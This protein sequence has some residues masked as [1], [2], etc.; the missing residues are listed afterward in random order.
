M[1]YRI[2]PHSTINQ[3]AESELREPP[4]QLRSLEQLKERYIQRKKRGVVKR[5][6][7]LSQPQPITSLREVNKKSLFRGCESQYI[8]RTSTH[9]APTFIP[10]KVSV[11]TSLLELITFFHAPLQNS[12]YNVFPLPIQSQFSL[13][14]KKCKLAIHSLFDVY[15]IQLCYY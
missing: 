11:F 15:D 2:I 12:N 3:I 5:W 6:A 8:F 14:N 1:W 4:L 9:L 7:K 10:A 13:H